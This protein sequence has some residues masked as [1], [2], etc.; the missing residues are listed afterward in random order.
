MDPGPGGEA[1]IAPARAERHLGVALAAVV[2]AFFLVR[3]LGEP[4]PHFPPTYPDSFSYLD[5]ARRGPLHGRFFFDERPIGYPFLLWSLGRSSTLTVL[6][7]TG[8]YVAAFWILCRVVFAELR[9]RVL[10]VVAVVFIASI[11]IEPRNALWNTLILSESLS[12]SLGVLSVAA[13][14]RAAARPSRRTVTWGWIAT[15]AW[16]LVRDTNVLPTVIVLLPVAL[17]CT[18]ASPSGDRAL[19]RCLLGGALAIVVVCGY[20]YVSQAV[21]HRTQYSVHNVVGM[22]V[23]PDAGLTRWFAEGGMPLDDALRG[24]TNH[25]AWD[26]NEA[27]LH[28]PELARYRTWAR[29]P[30]GHRLLLSMVVRW[31]DWW[32]RLHHDLPGILGE[33]DR[34]YDSYA[35]FD[36]FPH[37][38]PAPVGTPR[39]NAGLWAGLL[40]ATAGLGLAA[41]DRRRRLL[42]VVVGAGL[43]SAVVD[44]WCSYVGD[45]MEVNRHMVGPLARLSV[46]VIVAVALGADAATARLQ[47]A[48]TPLRAATPAEPHKEALAVVHGTPHDA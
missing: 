25:N 15:G 43:L 31:P 30:G 6:A 35:V 10:G 48:S 38:M 40:L 44:I 13:W 26:D 11:A 47:R 3:L 17:A 29:G 37:H 1:R 8:I 32:T 42:V 22:R 28:A 2:V 23:L 4:W 16:I 7:Q 34:A 14:L 33:D 19:R 27:F 20:V 24:R 18:W 46:L 21:S 36:R 9:S 41:G 45:P 39:T 12:T 5:V